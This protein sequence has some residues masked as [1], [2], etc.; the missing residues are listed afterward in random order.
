[1]IPSQF[2]QPVITV[3]SINNIQIASLQ[4]F[5]KPSHN[6]IHIF[7]CR[8]T[9][10]RKNISPVRTSLHQRLA[11]KSPHLFIINGNIQVCIDIPHYTVVT[12]HIN[13]LILGFLHHI[14]KG[15]SVNRDHHDHI[16]IL[17]NKILNLRNLLFHHAPG[18]LHIHLCPKALRCGNKHIPVPKPPLDYKR[19]KPQSNLQLVLFLFFRLFRLPLG[20]TAPSCKSQRQNHNQ[21]RPSSLF[22]F[23]YL[24]LYSLGVI[25]ICFLK[26]LL[27]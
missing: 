27:K 16:H 11:H 8:R 7:I 6:F 18:N 5:V 15:I 17:L 10:N 20:G 26:I 22:H 12:D 3:A 2:R 1:M 4:S 14:I 9:I 23:P 21:K 13:P 19:I 24:A 25:S